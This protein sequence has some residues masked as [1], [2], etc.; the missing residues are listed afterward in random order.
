MKIVYVI[1]QL[2]RGGAEQQLYYLLKY[3]R[4]PATVI[5]LEPPS[6]HTYWAEPI[7][8]LG[9]DVIELKRNSRFD[10]GRIQGIASIIRRERP[11]VVHVF[12]DTPSGIYGRMG[13]LLAGHR[14]VIIGERRHPSVDPGWYTWIKQ[15]WLNRHVQALVA[16]ARSTVEALANSIDPA[17]LHYVPNGLELDRF[18]HNPSFQRSEILPADWHDNIIIGTVG[19]LLPKKDPETFVT[20]ARQVIDRCPDARF[21]HTGIGPLRESSEALCDEWG[22]SD[23][24]LFLGERLDIP[25][26]LQSLDVFLMTSLNEGMPNAAMEAMAAGIPCVLTD[27]GDCRELVQE[28]QTGYVL[29][30]GDVDGLTQAVLRLAEDP[31]LRRTIGEQA[32]QAIQAYDVHTMAQR[33]HQIYKQVC[34]C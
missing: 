33:Y 22:I 15:I 11:D 25:R 10:L 18:K 17:K 1:G 2:R 4:L 29:P 21:V 8:E 20:V 31:V 12:T 6:E 34:V 27:T 3:L 14:C 28:A 30:I 13:A 16:N 32:R 5:S 19:S 23:R 7:R 9:H 26:I 24:V